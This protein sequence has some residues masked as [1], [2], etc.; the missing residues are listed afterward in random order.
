LQVKAQVDPK[1]RATY[2]EAV[3][4]RSEPERSTYTVSYDGPEG[5]LESDVDQDRVAVLRSDL[6]D[7]VGLFF[8]AMFTFVFLE[9]HVRAFNSVCS[10]CQVFV[11]FRGSA[12]YFLDIDG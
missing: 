3:V 12:Y 10:Q 5:K 11:M 8:G 4:V 7:Q 6:M 2:V 1:L 9:Q